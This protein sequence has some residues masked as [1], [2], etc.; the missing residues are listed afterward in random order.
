MSDELQQDF[1]SA[2]IHFEPDDVFVHTRQWIFVYGLLS[3]LLT[4][5]GPIQN[6]A[7][8]TAVLLPGVYMYILRMVSL[9]E[10]ITFTH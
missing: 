7:R 4:L 2:S 6:A 9:A 1:A 3:Y 10:K 8:I 5:L